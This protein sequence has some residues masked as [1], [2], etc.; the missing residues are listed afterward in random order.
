V[1]YSHFGHRPK[2]GA[3][4]EKPRRASFPAAGASTPSPTITPARAT[5]AAALYFYRCADCFGHCALETH[6]DAT[7]C[8]CGGELDY[9]GH[10]K[11]NRLVIEGV[12]VPCDSRC[13]NAIG[14]KCECGCF[15]A[16]HG[17]RAL[18][19]VE[20]DAGGVPTISKPA[21]LPAR[22]GIAEV[23]RARYERAREGY[24]RKVGTLTGADPVGWQ[25]REQIRNARKYRTQKRRLA[26]ISAAESLLLNYRK[27]THAG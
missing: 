12:R 19:H 4:V 8:D 26:A 15:G 24:D 5:T 21:D 3:E 23:F 27:P 18:V 9:L 6:N 1:S 16:N 2:L 17:T 10:A 25:I 20:V 14:P 22:L 7:R 13:T 11:N